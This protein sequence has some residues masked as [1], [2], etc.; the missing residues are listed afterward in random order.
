MGLKLQ[1][2]ATRGSGIAVRT[3]EQRY[4][5]DGCYRFVQHPFPLAGSAQAQGAQA[6]L[7]HAAVEVERGGEALSRSPK[8][9]L[10]R[11][12]ERRLR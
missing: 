12:V 8:T 7:V 6:S 4:R 1:R 2:V 5:N 10:Q 11:W 9:E 3:R